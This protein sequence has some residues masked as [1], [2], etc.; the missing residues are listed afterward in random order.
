MVVAI[1][2][3]FGCI[4]EEKGTTSKTETAPPSVYID[5]P[6]MQRT[7]TEGHPKEFVAKTYSREDY[8][9]EA[10]LIWTS[11][12]DGDIGQGKVITTD[13][14]SVG[15]HVITLTAYDEN[16][17]AGTYQ[18][19]IKKVK[20]PS[21]PQIE[22]KVEKAIIYI[23]RI[24]RTT[25]IDNR[26]DTVLDKNTDLMWL[27]TDDGYDR[28]YVEAYNYC[29]DL[30]FAG[31]EDWRLPTLEE[32]E[33]IANIGYGKLEPILCAVFE[34]K[35][36]AYYWTQTQ[37]DFSISSVAH[38]RYFD[39]VYFSWLGNKNGFVGITAPGGNE[40]RTFYARCVRAA[41]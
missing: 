36:H 26:D 22:K 28:P 11:D 23:D 24:D 37:S 12:L 13:V 41:L 27:I 7:F 15:E 21:M 5:I 19:K 40:F 2:F 32:L 39:V 9:D 18:I 1:V 10:Y 4:F 34:V 3:P 29:L 31:Y 35:N 14:L 20:R 33:E 38:T 17:N 8:I 25:Y 30:E 16:D 6:S